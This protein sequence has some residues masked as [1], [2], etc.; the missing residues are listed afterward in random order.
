MADRKDKKLIYQRI[1]EYIRVLEE[2]DIKVWRVYLYGSYAKD[3]YN[4]DSDI[5]LAIFL[6]KDELDGFEEDAKL[7]K[8]RRKMDI[9]IELHPFAKT[10]FK[11]SNSY[12][13]EIIK[14]GERII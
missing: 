14:T 7:M 2:N 1:Q 5:D 9:K 13:K 8:L 12:I 4:V 11:E 10:D 6:E 3:R